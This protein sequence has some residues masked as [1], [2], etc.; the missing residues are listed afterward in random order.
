MT[1]NL[2]EFCAVD[3][4]KGRYILG[5]EAEEIQ[6]PIFMAP[7][8]AGSLCYFGFWLY[9]AQYDPRKQYVLWLMSQR[10]PEPTKR[11]P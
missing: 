7:W 10:Y 8:V 9:T 5:A 1:S 11:A 6:M 2:R 4:G 3:S